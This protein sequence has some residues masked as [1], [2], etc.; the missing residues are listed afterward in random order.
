[1]A[2]SHRDTRIVKGMLLRGDKQHDIAAYFSVNGARVAEVATG[3]C[4]YPNAEP[5]PVDQLP[6]PGPYLS[7]YALG[8]V[9]ETLDEAIAAID[10][11]D[12]QEDV[13]DVK[14]ALLL[15]KETIQSKMTQLRE[16]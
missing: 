16:I 8:S 1:M 11:A 4:A 12:A 3:D 10:L 5:L 9:L 13:A 14:A 15:A 2:L 7:K 6:P